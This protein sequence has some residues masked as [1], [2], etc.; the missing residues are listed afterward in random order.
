MRALWQELG[1][2]C[3]DSVDF[4]DRLRERNAPK[5]PRDIAEAY[6]DGWCSLH[7]HM[8]IRPIGVETQCQDLCLA[9]QAPVGLD[10]VELQHKGLLTVPVDELGGKSKLG[11]GQDGG[12][13][14]GAVLV[15]P[16]KPVEQP[17]G[18]RP[19]ACRSLVR[20]VALHECPGIFTDVVARRRFLEPGARPRAKESD[21]S[22][23]VCG[24]LS[25]QALHRLLPDEMVQGGSEVV[26]DLTNDDGNIARRWRREVEVDAIPSRFVIYL[27]PGGVGVRFQEGYPFKLEAFVQ[28]FGPAY[29]RDAAVE[30]GPIHAG[31][32]TGPAMRSDSKAAA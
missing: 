2:V 15:Y 16:V 12:Y 30:C 23:L 5:W 21:A 7:A 8:R 18:L 26:C 13:L 3:D 28:H 27:H 14:Q 32:A 24:W 10:R 17:E 22:A 11:Q 31:E 6:S 19:L 20:L 25:A 9:F 1:E 4:L 29:L